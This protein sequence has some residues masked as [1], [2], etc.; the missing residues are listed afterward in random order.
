MGKPPV[1]WTIA[2]FDPSSG[3][4]VT[5]DLKT[6][7]RHGC[8]GVAC[9]TALTVQNTLGVR[10]V[11][12]VSPATVR[13]TLEVLAD[14]LRPLAIKIGM[15]ATAEIVSVVADFVDS[16]STSNAAAASRVSRCP[17][18]LD[19][20]LLSSSGAE[21][22]DRRGIDA[23]TRRLL[24]L[25]TV[26][27]PNRH[28]AA[29]LTGVALDDAEAAAKALRRLG[30]AAVVVTGGDALDP[31]LNECTGAMGTEPAPTW[32]CEDVLVFEAAGTELVETLSSPRV[33]SAG[34][35]GTGCAFS[36]AIAC[37]LA[38]GMAIPAAVTA[39]KAF[40]TAAIQRAPGLG[41]GR[42]PMALDSYFGQ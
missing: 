26:V 20:V 28:E 29:A 25:A 6:M 2:G 21:L 9:I 16:L 15:L 1:V 38:Q 14:D 37:S 36:T 27:T 35:H 41:R 13:E 40:V 8:Y 7:S 4:G 30:A 22:L 24:P 3:A 5:A 12:P 34:T 32:R 33:A 23:L 18:V 17:V 31:E 11:E 10:R 42:G 39:A 19:P